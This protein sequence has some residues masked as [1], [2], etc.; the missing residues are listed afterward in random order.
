MVE[1]PK[2]N[3]SRDT[4]FTCADLLCPSCESKGLSPFYQVRNVPTHCT[5]IM[6]TREEALISPKGDLVLSFCK[7]CGF[8]TNAAFD[9]E[10]SE[11]PAMYEDQQGFSPTFSD[12][13]RSLA[14][15][16]ITKYHLYE[17]NIVEIGCGKGDF[18]ALLCELGGNRGIG[19]DPIAPKTY[20][21]I[22]RDEVNRVTFVRDYYSEMHGSPPSDLICCRHTLEHVHLPAEFVLT[23]RKAIGEHT[24]TIVFFEVP[25]VARILRETAFWDI[26]YE[27]CSYFSAGSLAR[28]FRSCGFEL[29]N[30]T[31]AYDEQYLLLETKAAQMPS[32]KFLELEESPE[33]MAHNLDYF[34][35]RINY[36]LNYWIQ[37]LD[38]MNSQMKRTVIWGSGS[39][40]MAFLTAC[41]INNHIEYVIDINPRRQGKF[42]PGVG[43]EIIPPSF[44]KQY[45]P[46][47][48]IVMNPVY[49][50]EIS[51][52]LN[53][54]G[55]TAEIIPLK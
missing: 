9:P 43:L 26:Y 33:D 19:I 32:R 10:I 23:V 29:I 37:R 12:Y 11:E 34:C 40:C 54:I 1:S 44:L 52:M 55:V 13:A 41:D 24:R 17:K 8:I 7:Y 18:L 4:A 2:R 36:K 53:D 22:T 38:Q 15:M 46:D 6:P 47:L 30:L 31:R 45:Q 48:V 50:A 27:H 42:I 49:Y 25:D 14:D 5:A 21:S 16:L 35:N 20:K 28:L 51:N 3:L 39:K